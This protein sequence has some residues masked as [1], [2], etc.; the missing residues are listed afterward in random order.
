MDSDPIINQGTESLLFFRSGKLVSTCKTNKL[1][2]LSEHRRHLFWK[3]YQMFLY[4]KKKK[5]SFSYRST[6][7]LLKN[8]STPIIPH[9]QCSCYLIHFNSWIHY[10]LITKQVFPL[11][12]SSSSN[13]YIMDVQFNKLFEHLLREFIQGRSKGTVPKN[14]VVYRYLRHISVMKRV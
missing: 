6:N 7:Q 4:Q 11:F 10:T 12:T 13:T 1:F 3:V 14:R 9:T 5:K 8:S 2:K